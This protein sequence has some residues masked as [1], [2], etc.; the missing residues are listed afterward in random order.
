MLPNEAK[1]LSFEK[2]QIWFREKCEEFRIHWTKGADWIK[3]NP[4]N[5][6]LNSLHSIQDCNLH[7]VAIT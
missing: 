2:K 6:L 3:V 5:I 4:D 1:N 7:K